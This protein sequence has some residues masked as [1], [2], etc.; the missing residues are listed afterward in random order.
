MCVD[1]AAEVT[2]CVYEYDKH[3]VAYTSNKSR[4]N[5]E[6]KEQTS[7]FLM[8]ESSNKEVVEHMF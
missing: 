8:L 7:S 4:D 6:L 1:G 2:L 3:N 5:I